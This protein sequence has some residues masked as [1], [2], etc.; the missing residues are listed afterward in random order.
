M[1]SAWI[2]VLLVP[3]LSFADSAPSAKRDKALKNINDEIQ[4]HE[5]S[6][7]QCQKLG[8]DIETLR[9]VYEE[10]DK[11]VLPTLFRVT[12]SFKPDSCEQFGEMKDLVESM[13]IRRPAAAVGP[14]E[15]KMRKGVAA[16]VGNLR[17]FYREALLND[18]V[19]FLTA[20]SRL[21]DQ[22]QKV[23]AFAIAGNPYGLRKE[24]YDAIDAA[25][26]GL[27]DSAPI[28]PTSQLC[29]K[30][31]ERTNAPFFQTY[32]PPNTFTSRDA[33]SQIRWYTLPMYTLGEKPLWPPSSELETTYRL[34]YVPSLPFSVITLSLASDGDGKVTIKTVNPYRGR[35]KVDEVDETRSVTRDQVGRFYMQLDKSNFWTTPTELPETGVTGPDWILEGVKDGKYRVVV[36]RCP[37]VER[38][39]PEE[40]QFAKA[41][42]LL[43]EIAGHKWPNIFDPN[44][45]RLNPYV[46]PR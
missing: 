31:L 36:R 33:D 20:M 16:A 11:S 29:L 46:H 38:Q 34:T 1:K 4:S 22:D 3:I 23:I 13:V 42:R 12:S 44:C 27:P 8:A 21:P 40:S 17:E 7:R 15:S 2:L 32:F 43:F 39:T 24:A 26:K 25:L 45:S 35:I 28:G 5:V 9:E 14:S 10:G 19:G 30:T 18:P 41:G 6:S 37:D